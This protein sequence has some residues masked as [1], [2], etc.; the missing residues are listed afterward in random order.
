MTVPQQQAA[1]HCHEC[2]WFHVVSGEG[3]EAIGQCRRYAPA[4]TAA[5][6][7]T[8][9]TNLW[10]ILNPEWDPTKWAWPKCAGDWFCGDF[11]P[12]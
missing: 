1:Y 10:E 7:A 3:E 6:P 5:Q 9:Y 8:A 2:R 4:P 12:W 11:N